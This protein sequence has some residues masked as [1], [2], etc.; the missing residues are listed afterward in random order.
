MAAEEALRA[1]DV[2]VRDTVV[3]EAGDDDVL[4]DDDCCSVV[5]EVGRLYKKN[6]WLIFVSTFLKDIFTD[7]LLSMSLFYLLADFHVLLIP[8]MFEVTCDDH[9]YS[10]ILLFV[11]WLL[12]MFR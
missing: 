2:K 6:K 11:H 7:R 8:S 12:S 4:L 3:R 9:H 1:D 5:D 10:T